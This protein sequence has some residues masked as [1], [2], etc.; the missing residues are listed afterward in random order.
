MAPQ[1]KTPAGQFCPKPETYI[2]AFRRKQIRL[3]GT[4]RIE[5]EKESRSAE[6]GQLLFFFILLDLALGRA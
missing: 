1:G 2:D 4:E 6:K 5:R 3:H